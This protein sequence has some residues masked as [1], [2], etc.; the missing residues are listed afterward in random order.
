MITKYRLLILLLLIHLAGSGCAAPAL[1]APTPTPTIDPYYQARGAGDPRPAGYW[2][3]WNSCA[4]KNRAD[5]AA[6]N[7]GRSAG[8]ILMDDLLADPGI[9]MGELPLA[10]C[11]QGLRLLQAQDLQGTDRAADGLYQVAGELLAAQL[12]MAAGA[13]HCPAAD[14]AVQ[15]G[16]LM[17]VASGFNGRG[18]YT[19][20]ISDEI[21][22]AIP[23][24][25]KLL[26]DYNR[27]ALCR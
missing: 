2:L 9:L 10:T 15:A 21:A 7:G 23:Q 6:A 3:L 5:I 13:E 16:Q 18:T 22:A 12:N 26:R 19:A 4:P 20:A 8:W 24:V 11:Q 14:E 1:P 17:L 25:T 27:G